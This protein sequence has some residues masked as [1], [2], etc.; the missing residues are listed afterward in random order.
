MNTKTA[1][2][3]ATGV[4]GALFVLGG[5]FSEP[6]EPAAATG[7]YTIG[8]ILLGCAIALGVIDWWRDREGG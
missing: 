8:C 4:A 7:L 6:R 5:V 1:T 3:A 2:K